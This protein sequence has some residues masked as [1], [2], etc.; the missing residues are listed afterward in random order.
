[1]EVTRAQLRQAI[2]EA[3]R[4]APRLT[5]PECAALH[6]V[7][8]TATEFGTNFDTSCPARLAGVETPEMWPV[9][10]PVW[11]F[12][13]EFDRQMFAIGGSPYHFVEKVQ[14]LD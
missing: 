13:T 9:P 2:R 4:V 7:A 5:T 3:I 14:V 6:A 10:D 12:V 8:R 11:D 1:M